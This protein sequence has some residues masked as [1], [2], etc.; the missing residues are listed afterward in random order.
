[1]ETLDLYVHTQS[2]CII[3]TVDSWKALKSRLDYFDS[4]LADKVHSHSIT[5]YH[6]FGFQNQQGQGQLQ[7]YEEYVQ[8]KRHHSIAFQ[9]HKSDHHSDSIPKLKS[10]TRVINP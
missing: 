5:Y 7:N 3:H 1:M 6:S 8:S 2:N 10:E 4:G 9:I